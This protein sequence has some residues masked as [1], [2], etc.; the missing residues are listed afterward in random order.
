[1][2]IDLDGLKEKYNNLEEE[3]GAL[4]KDLESKKEMLEKHEW[5]K[6]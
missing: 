6:L 1:M 5:E 4:L 2:I 3:K